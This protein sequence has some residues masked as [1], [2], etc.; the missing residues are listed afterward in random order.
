[1]NKINIYVAVHKPATLYGD[2][3]YRFIHVG[4]DLH[5]EVYIDGALKDNGNSDN[6]SVKN[7][8][9]CELTGLYYLWKHVN[10]IE[11][12]GFV[13]YR[14][15]LAHKQF[16]L[17]PNNVI[18]T[19]QD[20]LNLLNKVD[21]VL[22]PPTKKYGERCGYFTIKEDIPEF[23]F[24]RLVKPSIAR[25]FP[26]YLEA[27]EQEFITP[28]MSYGNI[29]ACKKTLFNEYCEWLFAILFDVEQ[30]LRNSPFNVSAREMGYFSEYLLNVWIRKKQLTVSY[31]PV[32]FINKRETLI[33]KT[34]IYMQA[35]GLQFIVAGA[36]KIYAKLRK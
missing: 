14:R 8:I 16:A 29:M 6:I 9:Y 34:R 28:T 24:Y 27:F 18:L 26:E 25:L 32:C 1:M 36:E 15:F 10:D 7:D 22:T 30:N 19:E 5:P 11:Y 12:I 3:C 21:V 20:Y 13:H 35:M 4:A 17:Q 33:D 31:K 23:C 2:S